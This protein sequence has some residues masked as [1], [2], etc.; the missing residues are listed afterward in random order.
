M[1]RTIDPTVQALLDTPLDGTEIVVVLEVFWTSRTGTEIQTFPPPSGATERRW[2]ADRSIPGFPEVK[3]N[4]LSLGS[5]D[6]AVQVTQGGQSKSVAVELDDTDDGELKELF[7]T[8][9]L[10][11]IPVRVWFYVMG[12]DFATKKFPIFLGQ[13]NT[14]VVWDEGKRTFSFNVVNRRRGSRVLG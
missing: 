11:K 9:D 2:Y 6:A 5:V 13:I 12:T 4:I 14:P 8:N 1:A 3:S 10:H 7:D